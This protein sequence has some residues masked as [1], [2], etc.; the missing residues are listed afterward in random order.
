MDL[1]S[2]W[3]DGEEEGATRAPEV[4]GE[5][6]GSGGSPVV[7]GGVLLS[8][9]CGESHPARESSE[10]NFCCDDPGMEK[11]VQKYCVNNPFYSGVVFRD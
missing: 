11:S 3:T 6:R 7:V 4:A 10:I 9:V 2:D 5:V 1:G 8:A